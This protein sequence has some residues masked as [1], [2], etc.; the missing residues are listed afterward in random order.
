MTSPALLRPGWRET[1]YA[2]NGVDLHVVEA[3][4][5]HDPL[6]VLLHGF[7]EFWWGWR[8]L[9]DPLAAAGY[10]VVVPDMRGYN[11]SSVPSGVGAYSLELLVADVIALADLFGAES[12]DLAG[13]DW[14]AAVAWWAAATHPERIAHAAV[15]DGPHP[16]VWGRQAFKHPSQALRSSYVAVFQVPWLPEIVL[17]S[18]GFAALKALMQS[19][20]LPETFEPDAMDHYAQSWARPGRLRAMLNYYRALRRRDARKDERRI[21][22]PVLILWGTMDRFLERH[23]MEAGLP[24]CENGSFVPVEG[25]THWLLL[26]Q[27]ERV[28]SELLASLGR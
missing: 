11:L 23:V 13:H 21:V 1:I 16:D 27:P 19:S 26:E 20:A 9:I 28:T 4:S 12:F 7:P 2:V 24:L 18:F 22:P 6:L 3:G 5:P 8:K 25:A 10:H 14:G 15:L 17:S